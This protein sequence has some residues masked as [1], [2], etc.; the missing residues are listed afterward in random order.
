MPLFKPI[1]EIN[2]DNLKPDISIT[3]PASYC[4]VV[5]RIFSISTYVI[6]TIN[7]DGILR[8]L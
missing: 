6:I 7:S 4:A 8:I 1:P 2:T 5:T 3:I